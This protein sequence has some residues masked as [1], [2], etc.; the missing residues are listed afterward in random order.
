MSVVVNDSPSYATKIKTSAPG[1]ICLFGEHQD[2]LGLQ[3]IA[4]AID[5][6]ITIEA[7]R[8]NDEM[9]VIYFLD[10]GEV[11]QFNPNEE[12]TYRH[13]RDYLPAAANVLRREG[14]VWP[15]GYNLKV[16]SNIPIN[17]GASSSS[18]LQV[19]FCAFL[20][21]AA[22]DERATEA[23]EVARFAH[24]SEVVEFHSPG[25]MM[26]HYSTALGGVIWLDCQLPVHLECL[27]SIPGE[28]VLVDSGIPKDTNGVLGQKRQSV[29]QMGVDFSKVPLNGDV[30]ET[31]KEFNV[32]VESVPLLE[33][34]LRNRAL[35]ATA[36][37]LIEGEFCGDKLGDL[38]NQH[39]FQLSERLGI[40]HPE[41]D[42]LLKKGLELGADGGKI[43]GSGGG[44]SFFFYTKNDG[45]KI[46]QEFQKMGYRCWR[47]AISP[48]LKV[49]CEK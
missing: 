12:N 40:S 41:I 38:L 2:Y 36:K 9:L 23:K 32:P 27:S 17:G 22:N 11:D 4:A 25:G 29:E 37:E 31:A 43:N 14:L 44:G 26:D 3:V 39:H 42:K 21:A 6:R 46:Y 7:T 30:E 15:V 1:R 18:A 47:V 34:N 28:F 8:R 20:L 48:G 19:A 16:H 49:S 13:D 10:L 24:L 33:A 35:T 5:L 45:K